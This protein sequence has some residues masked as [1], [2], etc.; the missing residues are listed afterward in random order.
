MVV[1]ARGEE[2]AEAKAVAE[3]VE[4]VVQAAVTVKVVAA[5][6]TKVL[7]VE[8]EAEAVVEATW[9]V[10]EEIEAQEWPEVATEEG[11]AALADLVGRVPGARRRWPALPCRAPQLPEW[12]S[13]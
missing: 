13:Q 11:M 2:V 3:K 10:R 1:V 6:G 9:E 8:Q 12:T 5:A 7:V 4:V